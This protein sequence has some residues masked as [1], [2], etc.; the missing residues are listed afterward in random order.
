MKFFVLVLVLVIS[1]YP[2]SYVR[3]VWSKKNYLGAVG[4]VFLTLMSVGVPAYLLFIR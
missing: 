4:M 1:V 2:L 3:Y